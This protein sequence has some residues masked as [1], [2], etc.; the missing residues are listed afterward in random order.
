VNR[1][2]LSHESPHCEA[3][4]LFR[5]CRTDGET[6]EAIHA[7]IQ[8]EPDAP[9][10]IVLYREEIRRYFDAFIAAGRVC[11]FKVKKKHRPKVSVK[12]SKRILILQ[13]LDRV[14]RFIERVAWAQSRIKVG[15]FVEPPKPERPPLQSNPTSILPARKCTKKLNDLQISAAIRALQTGASTADVAKRFGIS[16]QTLGRYLRVRRKGGEPISKTWH[17]IRATIQA[18]KCAPE[19]ARAASA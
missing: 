7:L 17:E 3:A 18:D 10:P 6:I 8:P 9:E 15:A 16:V 13:Q 19:K 14:K 1:E 2:D 5:L 12:E 11:R 4:A